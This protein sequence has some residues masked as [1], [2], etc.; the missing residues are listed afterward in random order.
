MEPQA[1]QNMPTLE[2]LAFVE[3]FRER[4]E[5]DYSEYRKARARYWKGLAWKFS[6]S[7]MFAAAFQFLI[8]SLGSQHGLAST[9]FHIRGA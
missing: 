6:F 4:V 9:V 8:Y 7:V 2:D 5:S 1:A 3:N